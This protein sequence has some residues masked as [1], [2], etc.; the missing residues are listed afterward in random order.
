MYTKHV[1]ICMK[2]AW[3]VHKFAYYFRY[4]EKRI[5][6]ACLIYFINKQHNCYTVFTNL[7]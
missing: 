7:N 3:I 6:G 4:T 5:S 1:R 2:D